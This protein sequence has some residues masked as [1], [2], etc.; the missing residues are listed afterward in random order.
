M[1]IK[2]IGQAD[3]GAVEYD[4][5]LAVYDM[6]THIRLQFKPTSSYYAMYESYTLDLDKDLIG[7][8]I[9]VP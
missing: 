3:R 7:H 4:Q 6:N 8:I 5:V 2:I 1:K 9:V